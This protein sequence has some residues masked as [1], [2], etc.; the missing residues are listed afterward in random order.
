MKGVEQMGKTKDS[1]TVSNECIF[2]S[3]CN[4]ADECNSDTK[5]CI[6]FKNIKLALK[7]VSESDE[8]TEE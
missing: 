4:Y 5:T 6:S 1:G 7:E 2:E 8:N 3:I